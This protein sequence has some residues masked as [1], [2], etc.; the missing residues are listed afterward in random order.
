MKE[1]GPPKLWPFYDFFGPDTL[2]MKFPMKFFD[3]DKDHFFKSGQKDNFL[4]PSNRK[5]QIF[6]FSFNRKLQIFVISV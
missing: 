3:I 4:I 1:I 6:W 2:L 5:V